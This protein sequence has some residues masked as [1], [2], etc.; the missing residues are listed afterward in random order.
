VAI[1]NYIKYFSLIIF[2]NLFTY[3]EILI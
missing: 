1:I 2:L 3:S